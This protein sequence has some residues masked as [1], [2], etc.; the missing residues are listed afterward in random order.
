MGFGLYTCTLVHRFHNRS[1]QPCRRGGCLICRMT[2]WAGSRMLFL[3]NRKSLCSSPSIWL[4]FQSSSGHRRLRVQWSAPGARF[5]LRRP[6]LLAERS[7]R[8]WKLAS[9]PRTSNAAFN[10]DIRTS[11][12]WIS[13][14]LPPHM[15]NLLDCSQSQALSKLFQR[16]ALAQHGIR[17][18]G[19]RFATR[20]IAET[21]IYL[22]RV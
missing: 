8:G 4:S 13:C 5:A 3:T 22:D 19:L 1:W 12:M 18:P 15:F 21:L 14:Q 6:C 17:Q 11:P 16:D 20:I 10:Q 2:G 7:F 9:E